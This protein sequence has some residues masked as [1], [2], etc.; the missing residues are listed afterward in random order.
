MYWDLVWYFDLVI[1]G[2]TVLTGLLVDEAGYFVLEIM[3]SLLLYLGMIST[4]LL[5]IV[6]S[7]SHKPVVNVHGHCGQEKAIELVD[8]YST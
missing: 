6:D 4:I 3:F 1:S 7:T 2:L 5:W 8:S